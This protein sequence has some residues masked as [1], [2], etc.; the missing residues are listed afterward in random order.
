MAHHNFLTEVLMKFIQLTQGKQAIV[1]DEDFELLSQFKW[2]AMKSG[3]NVYAARGGGK[4]RMELLHRLILGVTDSKIEVDH[5]NGDG[6]DNRR[7][8]LRVATHADNQHN[9]GTPTNN[10]SG[11]K[12]VHWCRTKHK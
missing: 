7:S 8:N 10:T 5:I 12:G 4:R 1:D 9:P 2:Y 11:Y 6:L 3:H